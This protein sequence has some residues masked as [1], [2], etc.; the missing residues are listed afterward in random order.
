[1]SGIQTPED[2][3]NILKTLVDINNPVTKFRCR[4]HKRGTCSLVNPKSSLEGMIVAVQAGHLATKEQLLEVYQAENK[5]RKYKSF[6]EFMRNHEVDEL[7][8]DMFYAQDPD[9]IEFFAQLTMA[10][11]NEHHGK[12]R[13]FIKDEH[14]ILRA[15]DLFDR[16]PE[17]VQVKI[18]SHAV[19]MT[20]MQTIRVEQQKLLAKKE[21]HVS[22]WPHV[23]Y[24]RYKGKQSCKVSVDNGL[25]VA[26][27]DQPTP[28]MHFSFKNAKKIMIK[29]H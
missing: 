1:M 5:R 25:I 9:L 3:H 29:M 18:R 14:E 19:F 23:Q 16:V 2:F 12:N 8:K 11:I 22:P 27:N 28:K 17:K 13:G 20:L 26:I 24:V 15:V 21:H 10:I 6:T 4:G 7:I